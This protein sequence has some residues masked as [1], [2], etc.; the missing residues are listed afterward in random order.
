MTYEQFTL[1]IEQLHQIVEKPAAQVE[2]SRELDLLIRQ[3]AAYLESDEALESLSA[4]PYWP[5]WNSPWWRMLLLHE[6]GSGDL[7]PNSALDRMVSAID[8]HYLHFFPFNE[9]ELPDNVDAVRHV[10]CHCAL[11]TIYQVLAARGIDVDARLN[12]VRPWFLRYQL[13]DGGLNCDEAA[14]TR[15]WK[16]SSVVSTLPAVEAVLNYTSHPF[17]D[18]E[19]GFLDKGADYLIRRR[20]F[21][22]ASTGQVID[23]EWTKLCFPRFYF[24]D[25]LRGLSF[26]VAWS[27]HLQRKLPL[28]VIQEAVSIIDRRF[29]NGIVHVDR[30]AWSGANSRWCDPQTNNWIKGK[31]ASHSLLERVSELD[32]ACPQLTAQWSE[33]KKTILALID[34]KLIT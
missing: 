20:L 33:V 21:R 1:S 26:L 9:S 30:A 27:Q 25:I 23:Q 8:S 19:I 16:K 7:I 29:P 10:A 14:Y 32:A 13:G 18:E 4:D 31:A 11:G 17:T 28:S 6:M 15:K 22:S 3:S 34:L 2:Q 12:W 5:K 24:Y